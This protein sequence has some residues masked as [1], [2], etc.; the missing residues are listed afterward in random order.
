MMVR[1][2]A[3]L[4]ASLLAGC[5][6]GA[7]SYDGGMLSFQTSDGAT[8]SAAVLALT[9]EISKVLADGDHALLAAAQFEAL[10]TSAAGAARDW[11]NPATGHAGTVTPGPAY[12]VNQYSCRDFSQRV[13]VGPKSEVSRATACRQPDGTWRPIS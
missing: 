4:L 5:G 7:K 2:A 8:R 12:T 9:P 3:I 6:G 10:E 11:Q 1:H 13:V